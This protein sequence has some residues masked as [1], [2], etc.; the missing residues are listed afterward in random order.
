MRIACKEQKSQEWYSARIGCV[1]GS[2]MARAMA[3]LSRASGKKKKGDWA[4]EHD[5][6]VEEIAW[7]LITRVPAEHYVTK[8]MD[9]GTQ[10]ESEAR[11]EWMMATGNEVEQVGF[12]LHPTLNY[13]G[14]SPDGYVVEDG[15]FIPLEL[16]VPTLKTHERYLLEDEM[17]EEY[18]PQIQS[19]MV[20]CDFAPYAYFSS[21][22]PPEIY[23]ELPEEFRL[24]KKRV[25][26]IPD[27]RMIDEPDFKG[28]TMEEAA[29]VT[30]EQATALAAR[31][32]EKYPNR[33]T[34][35]A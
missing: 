15:L 28:P 24:F 25:D 20:C 31:L 16:K 17:P 19:E 30:M 35:E 5:R 14:S 33:I 1:T 34:M 12:V 13:W 9:I 29:T 18:M 26:F 22:A 21:Y 8:A 11:I 6:Y 10:Y 7:E 32:R 23:P 27:F 4:A 2:S 3:I